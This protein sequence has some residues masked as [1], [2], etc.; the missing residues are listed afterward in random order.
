MEVAIAPRES[1]LA[2]RVTRPEVRFLSATTLSHR[3]AL[4]MAEALAITRRRFVTAATT[5][6][7]LAA[8]IVDGF[9]TGKR[10]IRIAD[11]C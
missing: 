3:T 2:T 7:F 10:L 4:I 9:V 6:T 1:A 5:A 11:P 8:F